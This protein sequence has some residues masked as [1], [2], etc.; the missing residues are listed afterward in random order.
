MRSLYTSNSRA[1]KDRIPTPIAETCEWILRDQ[2]YLTWLKQG[3]PNLL[4]ICAQAGSGKSVLMSY[5]VETLKT[6]Q[7]DAII[8]YFFYDIGTSTRRDGSALLCDVLHQAFTQKPSLIQHGIKDF[9]IKGDFTNEIRTLWDILS[10]CLEDPL[11]NDMY[12]CIDG[13]DLCEAQSG[14]LLLTWLGE[15]FSQTTNSKPKVLLSSLPETYTR[16]FA[17]FYW[18]GSL[19]GINN[20]PV[21]LSSQTISLSESPYADM[22]ERDVATFIRKK[23]TDICKQKGLV[24]SEG[25]RLID[26]LLS[27]AE[28]IFLWVSVVVQL[29]E[30]G[31][32]SSPAS[33]D[34]TLETLPGNLKD[35][36]SRILDSINHDSQDKAKKMLGIVACARRPLTLN[37]LAASF[38]VNDGQ[39]AE[40]ELEHYYESQIKKSV[41][42]L[43]KHF[44]R[45]VDDKVFFVHQTAR[46]FLFSGGGQDRFSRLGDKPWYALAEKECEHA[47]ATI[48][49]TYLSFTD[50]NDKPLLIE[51]YI[52]SPEQLSQIKRYSEKHPFLA[53]AS[54]HWAEHFRACEFDA[55]DSLREK[56]LRISNVALKN[57]NTWFLVYWSAEKRKSELPLGLSSLHVVAMNGHITLAR[58]ILK[59]KLNVNFADNLR[60]TPLFWAVNGGWEEM[61]RLLLESG[62][63]SI[64]ESTPVVPGMLKVAATGGHLAVVRLLLETKE[65]FLKDETQSKGFLKAKI[66]ESSQS[67]NTIEKRE[68]DAAVQAAIRGGHVA[69]MKKLID[70]ARV[71]DLKK[72][73]A[74]PK[75]GDTLDEAL[76]AAMKEG[77]R[78]MIRWLQKAGA[79][80]RH[81]TKMLV[82]AVEAGNHQLVEEL[83]QSGADVGY[84]V[85]TGMPGAD[86]TPLQVA[87]SRGD[88]VMVEILI[89]AGANVND[90]PSYHAGTTA[91]QAAVTSGNMEVVDF[92]LDHGADPKGDPAP[93]Q[94]YT[95]LQA[96]AGAGHFELAQRLVELGADPNEPSPWRGRSPLQ[97]AARNGH[98]EIV[99]WLLAKGADID[100]IDG[101]PHWGQTAWQLAKGY[102]AVRRCLQEAGARCKEKTK[103][104][105]EEDDEEEEEEVS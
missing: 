31:D 10:R 57:F 54:L 105:Y 82:S 43:C 72:G 21:E 90:P 50:F 104:D 83:L 29:L 93:W 14:R 18:P 9:Q 3:N 4:W 15:L 89:K 45:I 26:K 65:D 52:R 20:T 85:D 27:R 98:L 6:T 5:L 70:W 60:R 67:S 96:A 39:R 49:T 42:D 7:P 44:L 41:E 1:A 101:R 97:A 64:F 33:M 11:C 73:K 40:S 61:V 78:D 80:I 95:A 71:Q 68:V 38:A 53:Y 63:I 62:A 8:C 30:E 81:G 103:W 16:R 94:G 37:E 32:T 19:K 28:K 69:V 100:A 48:C 99:K 75:K 34:Q 46:D 25:L 77:N 58:H 86:F 59:Q 12:I 66:S 47:L 24:A 36:Y 51:N 2:K 87:A 91:L 22:V 74:A 92:L 79:K 35:I 88:L 84:I 23:V 13:F 55:P 76:E 102:P 56:G 17:E